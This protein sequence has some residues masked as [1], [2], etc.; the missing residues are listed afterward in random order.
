MKHNAAKHKKAVRTAE[1][2]VKKANPTAKRKPTLAVHPPETHEMKVG[3]TI[4]IEVDATVVAM[5]GGVAQVQLKD[6]P[7]YRSIKV[8][9]YTHDETQPGLVTEEQPT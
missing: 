6:N 2:V 7:Q 8:A 1:K 3:D 5:G 4:K 9:D